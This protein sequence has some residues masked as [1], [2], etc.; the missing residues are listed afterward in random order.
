MVAIDCPFRA[1]GEEEAKRVEL[2]GAPRD[3]QQRWPEGGPAGTGRLRS[4]KKGKEDE[5]RGG[6]A[7]GG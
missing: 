3:F 4:H 7:L 2:P 6:S 1:I 5:R